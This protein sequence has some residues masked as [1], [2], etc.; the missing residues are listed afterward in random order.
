MESAITFSSDKVIGEYDD[1]I[2]PDF[3]G[4]RFMK[5]VED[6]IPEDYYQALKRNRIEVRPKGTY[7]LLLVHKAD[8]NSVILF[9]Y[10]CTPEVDGPVFL[11]HVKYD[12]KK[13]DTFDICGK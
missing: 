7:Y 4:A 11:D 10:S 8:D 6:R 2:P 12:P 9:D 5:F 1:S 3:D 13:V